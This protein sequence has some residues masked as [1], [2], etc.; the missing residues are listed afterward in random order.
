M[1]HWNAFRSTWGREVVEDAGV[2]FLHAILRR[3]P[4]LSVLAHDGI[5]ACIMNNTAWITW[6]LD[7]AGISVILK[8]TYS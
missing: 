6:S 7:M 8:Y 2:V 4:K 3:Y 5:S 1:R